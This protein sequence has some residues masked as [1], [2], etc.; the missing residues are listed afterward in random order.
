MTLAS[1]PGTPPVFL[2]CT[3]G[4]RLGLG[5]AALGNLFE[6][7]SQDQARRLIEA[8][9]DDGCRSFDTAPHYG[10]GLSE[11]RL[12]DALRP[13]PRA[14]W[15]LSSK[16]GRLLRP[17][18]Q[19]GTTHHGYVQTLPFSQHWDFS[20]AG[21]ER[22]IE[23]SLHRL[24][25]AQI[26]AVFIHD[27]D[28]PTQGAKAAQ[29]LEQVLTEVLPTLRRLQA[30]GWIGPIGLGVNEVTVVHDLLARA[31]LDALLLAG[32]YSLLDTSALN[33]LLPQLQKKGVALALGGVF[34][35]GILA[36]RLQPGD[37]PTF[38]YQAAPGPWLER[39][40]Q[41]QSH[42]DRYEVT[43]PAAALQFALAHP[44]ASLVLLG[45]RDAAQ[46]HQARAMARQ[47]IDAGLWRDLKDAGLLPA[48]APTP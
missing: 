25:L 32:R 23:D 17:D 19:A 40:L 14:Q 1:T 9:W 11:R 46:W 13:H 31:D 48:Q 12:G 43:L 22:S 20:A 6:A 45:A 34:N 39:A 18:A 5:G 47:P 38:N 41:L 37:R 21:I 33:T 3:D 16:V 44:A 42:C 35:S 4:T 29:V 15:R 2:P 24:G 30:R 8:A 10:H 36:Q 28:A 26:D 7:V 27:I